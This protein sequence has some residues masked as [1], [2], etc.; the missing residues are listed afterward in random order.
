M[1][2]ALVRNTDV[3]GRDWTFNAESDAKTPDEAISEL[4][5]HYA[6]ELGTFESEIDVEL[7]P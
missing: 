2:K 3:L 6:Y 7:L 5:E 1:Y 4:K